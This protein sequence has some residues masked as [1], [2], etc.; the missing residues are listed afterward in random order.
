MSL[1]QNRYGY[2]QS[3]DCRAEA[4]TPVLLVLIVT[5]SC[6]HVYVFEQLVS[7]TSRLASQISE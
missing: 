5:D 7:L 4:G 3:A 1:Q 2:L 6:L